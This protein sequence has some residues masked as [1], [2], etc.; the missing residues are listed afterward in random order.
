M[1]STTPQIPAHIIAAVRE[2]WRE[3]DRARDAN[4]YGL[5]KAIREGLD[6]RAREY[7]LAD[8]WALANL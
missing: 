4:D 8:A 5:A 3:Y 1:A 6:Q 7:G 2:A